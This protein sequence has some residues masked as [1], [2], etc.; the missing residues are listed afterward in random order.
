MKVNF[1]D[2]RVYDIRF[3]KEIVKRSKG[4]T[5]TMH[6]R[7]SEVDE[8]KTGLEKY[9]KVAETIARQSPKDKT[10]KAQGR[11]LAFT[12]ALDMAKF[13]RKERLVFWHIYERNC[14][15]VR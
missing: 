13:S 5:L 12:R 15:V 1:Q 8:T 3:K 11:T 4:S 6:C 10:N 2:G 14:R 9:N 7:V